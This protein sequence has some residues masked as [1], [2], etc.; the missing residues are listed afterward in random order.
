ML[1][2]LHAQLLREALD[3][4]LSPRAL[5]A[6]ILGNLGQDNLR[7]QLGHD[8]Y[9]F[10]NNAFEKTR[11]YLEVQRG[12][13]LSALQRGDVASAW[14]SFGR[15]T[16]A[17]QDFYAHTNYVALWLSRNGDPAPA[18]D[19]I[20]P[21]DPELIT[22]PALRSGKTYYPQEALYFVPGLRR[23]ALSIL[24]RDSHAHMN[25]DSAEQGPLF[26]YAYQAALKRT[27]SEF[28]A[29]RSSL[30]PELLALFTDLGR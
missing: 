8:E 25:L 30:R 24:P 21:A 19:G 22:S 1:V 6:V 10:D 13:I 18:P 15:L 5:E 26:E 27:V 7:G 28:E 14:S 16:H 9:H 20:D 12:L 17:L 23:L 3:G 29:L 2:R 11:G 4:R